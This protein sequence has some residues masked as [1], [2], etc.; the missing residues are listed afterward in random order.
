MRRRAAYS[1]FIALVVSPLLLIGCGNS[2]NKNGTGGSGGGTGDAGGM[3]KLDGGGTGDGTGGAKIDGGAGRTDGGAGNTGDGGEGTSVDA[4]TTSDT[5]TALDSNALDGGSGTVAQQCLAGLVN[6]FAAMAPD[7]ANW[8]SSSCSSLAAAGGSLVLTQNEPCS[9]ASP[10]AIAG[11]APPNVLC[12]DFDVQV[13]FAVTGLVAG[14]TGG[15]FA[16]MRANDPTVTTNGMT[17][18]RYAAGY[19]PLSSQSYQN[20]KS[21]TT[22]KGDDATSVFVP[23]TDVTGRFRLTRAGT[24][25]KSYYWKTGA[26]DGQW[27]L[28]NT[29][30]LTNT[31]WVLV[32]YEG[33]NSAANKGPTAPYSVTFSN[34]LVTFPGAIDAGTGIAPVADAGDSDAPDGP[35]GSGAN[36]LINGSFEANQLTA[37]DSC[38]VFAWC[39]RSFSSTPGWTQILDGV[40][41]I[42]NNYQQNSAPVLVHASDGV[43]FL[44]MNQAGVLG[45]I[46]QVVTVNV[47]TNYRLTLDACA[48]ATNSVP[49]TIGYELYDPAS[50]AVLNSGSFTDSVGGTWVTRTLEAVALSS[51]IGVRIQG[52][53]ANQAGMGLDHVVLVP[54]SSGK[55]DGGGS[56]DGVASGDSSKDGAGAE[57]A[58]LIVNPS[59]ETPLVKNVAMTCYPGTATPE[60][61]GFN[62]GENIAGWTV[63]GPG[64]T[65]PGYAAVVLATSA[66]TENSG[67]TIYNAFDGDQSVDLSGT[68]NQ[69]ANGLSQTVATV[70]GTVYTLAFF[71]G[72]MDSTQ[73]LS[74]E[75]SSIALQI[76]NATV[77]TY[78]N[79]NSTPNHINWKQFTYTFTAATSSTKIVF[80]NATPAADN[81]CGLDDVTL[82]IASP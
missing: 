48:W 71:V 30:T 5:A 60:C 39:E 79:G 37:A 67:T 33:D 19:L 77:G 55:A 24:T 50:S 13:D 22:N 51:S 74:P 56:G 16:S 49:G 68:G 11:L 82:R 38:Q 66:Y 41:L 47:G 28:V 1:I 7:W 64:V 31:P 4:P 40:D 54:V 35:G 21:Y 53:A 17:I 15:I 59:F 62:V 12:G 32:L 76:D 9:A 20:Y 8:S 61:A 81:E 27:V 72:N 63:V 58:Q 10:N 43:Q 73:P 25:V 18:E 52:L 57:S 69:G 26:P 44:D 29:A 3:A 36:L 6:P 2:E 34:L 46:E 80:I 23:T 65:T 75:A 78:T 14:V 42:N 70:A 45:G